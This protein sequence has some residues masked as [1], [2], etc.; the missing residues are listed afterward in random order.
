MIGAPERELHAHGK[1][2]PPG[3]S[4]EL[5]TD[6]EL[7]LE[8]QLKE[9]PTQSL[10]TPLKLLIDTVTTYVEKTG[11]SACSANFAGNGASRR[12]RLRSRRALDQRCDVHD[13]E[14]CGLHDPKPTRSAIAARVERVLGG[15]RQVLGI[16]A[17]ENVSNLGEQDATGVRLL[18]KHQV[19]VV[20]RS[21]NRTP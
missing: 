14:P 2:A 20:A 15:G 9:P 7:L 19:S 11:L 13:G 10:E 4:T 6:R 5:E 18:Q 12:A 16:P 3:G 21:G 17:V 1:K 8:G